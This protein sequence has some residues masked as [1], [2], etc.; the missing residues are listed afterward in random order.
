MVRAKYEAA[1][2]L[3]LCQG[4]PLVKQ[5]EDA[6][7]RGQATFRALV[8]L[9]SKMAG[10]ASRLQQTLLTRT[11]QITEEMELQEKLRWERAEI[12]SLI[13]LVDLEER[14]H[15]DGAAAGFFPRKRG[16]RLG[17]AEPLGREEARSSRSPVRAGNG[18]AQH[19]RNEPVGAGLSSHLPTLG[20]AGDGKG[21]H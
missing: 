15:L 11:R 5:L 6:R 19:H 1:V 17:R 8:Q 7:M 13:H 20:R 2:H 12:A 3:R 21:A 10:T 18:N 16:D 4:M 9:Q 14:R